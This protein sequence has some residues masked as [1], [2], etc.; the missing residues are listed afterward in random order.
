M[1][2][3]TVAG[4]DK[5]FNRKRANAAA[6]EEV[7]P[8]TAQA[9]R[10]RLRREIPAGNALAERKPRHSDDPADPGRAARRVPADPA[11]AG[12][13]QGR[14]AGKHEPAKPA[15]RRADRIAQLTTRVLARAQRMILRKHPGRK[16]APRVFGHKMKL[17]SADA[18]NPGRQP[19]RRRNR[20]GLKPRRTRHAPART[21]RR[22]AHR[23]LGRKRRKSRHAT[24]N[25][26]ATP[27]VDEAKPVA[28]RR[29][30]R[31][32]ARKQ[33][34][35]GKIGQKRATDI[36]TQQRRNGK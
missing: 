8:E 3:A 32:P 19:D 23:T 28:Y 11:V 22:K 5:R 25:A 20:S 12:G 6:L 2:A 18:I 24:R 27:R 4:T 15:V 16:R 13:R 21:L 35:R 7:V 29:G 26:R 36:R 1:A 10:Q 17:K 33:I 31:H 14:R 9:R 30:K 34:R